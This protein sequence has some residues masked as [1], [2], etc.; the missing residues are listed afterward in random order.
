MMT[1]VITAIVRKN[2]EQSR[3]GGFGFIRDDA[4]NERFFHAR[5]LRGITFEKLREGKRVEFTPVDGQPTGKS[6][7]LRCEDVRVIC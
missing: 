3:N 1:G 4:N 2:K 6:N 5:N 7:G